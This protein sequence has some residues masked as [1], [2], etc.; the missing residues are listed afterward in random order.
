SDFDFHPPSLAAQYV[1]EDRQVMK[2]RMP[3]IDRPWLVPGADRVPLWYL[4]SK[5]PLLDAAGAVI[6][7]CGVMRPCA[8]LGEAP[9]E[10]RRLAPALAAVLARYAEPL[11]VGELA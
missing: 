11:T 6:G 3:L 5:L 2:R 10:Y 1:E 4:C 7:I 8:H 9:P